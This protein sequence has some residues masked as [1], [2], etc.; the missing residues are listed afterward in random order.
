MKWT[1][2]CSAS[3]K[4]EKTSRNEQYL[5]INFK[6][7]Y[8][9]TRLEILN[10]T[11]RYIVEKIIKWI[12]RHKKSMI[13]LIIAIILFPIIAIHLL[14]KLQSNCY[15]IEAEWN[16]GEILGYFGDVLA[17]VG[18]VVLGYIAIAQTEKANHLNNELLDIEKNRIKP[19]LDISSMSLYKIYLEE[20][21]KKK[22]NEINRSDSM[23][24]NLL[25]Y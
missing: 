18:T 24:V 12:M 5:M 4:D 11:G 15:W 9:Q 19:H 3:S 17:F 22:L 23:I 1:K 21:M 16:A 10:F 2:E 13:V 7:V 8:N 20:D 25:L 14:F 6:Q